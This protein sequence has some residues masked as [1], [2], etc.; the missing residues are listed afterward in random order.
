MSRQSISST[1]SPSATGYY[2]HPQP[3]YLTKGT[4]SAHKFAEIAPHVWLIPLCLY[5]LPIPKSAKLTKTPSGS[6]APPCVCVCS[7]VSTDWR[8]VGTVWWSPQRGRGTWAVPLHLPV[9]FLIR[10]HIG[11][12]ISGAC[13]A[14]ENAIK[15]LVVPDGG[16]YAW[17]RHSEVNW[18]QQEMNKTLG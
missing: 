12:V 8:W 7:L 9:P 3:L 1:Y 10:L 4:I 5:R 18:A 17:C 14:I 16:G 2:T 6:Q 15:R 13:R 11:A